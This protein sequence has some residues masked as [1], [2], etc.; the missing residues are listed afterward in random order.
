MK[1]AF[2]VVFSILVI[3]ILFPL[4]VLIGLLI[5]LDSGSGIVYKSK[6]VGYNKKKFN[7]YKF[8]TMFPDSDYLTITQGNSDPRITPIGY[9][10][11]KYK[12]DELPQL[13]NVL[14]GDMSFVGPRPDVPYY[15][16]Y[17]VRHM[18]EYFS[19][20]PGITSYASLY[21]SNE[22]ELYRDMKDPVNEYIN[23]TIPKKVQLD[24]KY[25]ENQNL[26]TDLGIILMTLKK[27]LT[28]LFKNK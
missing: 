11:R 3:L 10:L 15:S 22:S 20:K 16:E 5:W 27:V 8:R 7:L 26:P 24:K 25:Y 9:Y 1:R 12:L 17:Y 13:F 21:F 4:F 18:P 19:I 2:D 6:R 28:G 14:R 23:N